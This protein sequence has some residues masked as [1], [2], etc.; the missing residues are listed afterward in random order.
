[1]KEPADEQQI[2]KTLDR[3][4]EASEKRQEKAANWSPYD[5]V[6]TERPE[7]EGPKASPS[8]DTCS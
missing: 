7:E 5:E 2:Y 3:E 8:S 4:R 6:Q 1:M